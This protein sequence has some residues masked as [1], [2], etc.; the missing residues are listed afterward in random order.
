MKVLD[1]IILDKTGQRV[2][3]SLIVV[4]AMVCILILILIRAVK[5]SIWYERFRLQGLNPAAWCLTDPVHVALADMFLNLEQSPILRDLIQIVSSLLIDTAFIYNISVFILLHQT[6]RIFYAFM[7]FYIS[8]AF[9]QGLFTFKFP[10]GSY[11]E[12][13]GFPSLMVPYGAASDFYYSGHTGFFILLIREQFVSDKSNWKIIVCLFLS[14]SVMIFT[15]LLFKV[16][17]AIGKKWVTTL[18]IP[19]GMV[20]AYFCH[21]IAEKYS[22]NIDAICRKLAPSSW[23]ERPYTVETDYH[24]IRSDT[25]L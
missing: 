11:W 8:R 9:I 25:I 2:K 20:A 4:K 21:S 16:H 18:D 10:I 22:L 23:R 6:G 12:N 15:I 13:P 14:M 19:I 5:R 24:K 7:I 17:Y 3:L 1:L